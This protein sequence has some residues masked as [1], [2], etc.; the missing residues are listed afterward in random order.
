MSA[1]SGLNLTGEIDG[2][3]LVGKDLLTTVSRPQ[4]R[5]AVLC[6]SAD[7]GV[8]RPLFA[9]ISQTWN[10][11]P[12]RRGFFVMGYL[13]AWPCMVGPCCMGR[14]F[15]AIRFA[16]TWSCRHARRLL[17][18][19]DV[20]ADRRFDDAGARRRQ[21]LRQAE[22]VELREELLSQPHG[23]LNFVRSSW[24]FRRHDDAHA[25][26]LDSRIT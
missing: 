23:G 7:K 19:L 21:L 9:A 24:L 17:L 12:L 11:P 14:R 10:A 15:T 8:R 20:V 5:L 6:K 1:V 22:I 26:N 25:A 4:E 3:G 18:A 2:R 13:S 16:A